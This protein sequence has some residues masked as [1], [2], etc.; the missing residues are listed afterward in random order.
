MTDRTRAHDP[1]ESARRIE[2][3]LARY[4]L[5]S[6]RISRSLLIALHTREICSI[7]EIHERARRDRAA[8][9][10]PPDEIEENVPTVRRWDELERQRV[11]ELTHECAAE[12]LTPEEIDDVVNLARKREEAKTLEEI[13]NL[14]TVSFRTLAERVRA[15]ARLPRG[16]TL[17][18]EAEAMAVRVALIRHFISDQLELIGIARQH[19]TIRDFDELVD[20][21][22]GEESGM[23]R[24]GGKAA[25]MILARA[26]VQRA[27]EEDPDAPSLPLATPESWYLRSD[28]IERFLEHEALY[29]LHSHKYK[30]IDEIRNEYPLIVKLFKNAEFP[31]EIAAQLRDLLEQIGEHPL[32]VRS[33]SLLEDR[34]GAAFAGKYRSVFIANQGPLDQRLA[35]LLGAIAEVYAS[36][37]HPDPISYRRRHNLLDYSENMAVLIQKVVGQRY[38]RWFLPPW[39]GVAVSNNEFRRNPR[40]RPEDGLARVVLGMGTRAVDR[41]DDFPR[42]IPLGMPTLRAEVKTRDIVRYSQHH[43]DAIDLEARRLETVPLGEVLGEER[44]PGLEHAVSVLDHGHLRRPVGIFITAEPQDLV[45]TFERFVG[46]SPYPGFLRWILQTLERAYGQPVEIEFAFDGERLHLLQCRPQVVRARQRPVPMPEGVPER[47]KVFSAHRD[48]PNGSV[49]GIDYVVLVDPRH[50]DPLPSNERRLGVARAIHRLN[51]RLANHRF[52]LMGP[53]RWGSKDPRMGIRAGYSDINN[54]K[55][56]IEVA[57][58]MGGFIP[59]ASFGSHFFHDLVESEIVYLPLYPDEPG[60]IFNESFLHDAPND[61]ARLVPE[62]ADYADV[63]RAIHVPEVSGGLCLRVDMDGESGEALAYLAP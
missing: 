26:I 45:V 20:R 14:S 56:L 5:L 62:M 51:A 2:E 23:G 52:I 33:S 25:G 59:E 37:L 16:Q 24:I 35:E 38:G 7:D 49:S 30:P 46:E 47:R 13:A 61:L 58:E 53:G 32:I 22:I 27:L 15:F 29:Q 9:A 4:P 8:E 28:V 12:A 1:A 21:I 18:P 54:T 17:L 42:M 55:M 36:T 39:A 10:S 40:V 6:E 60:V 3:A 63:V 50:Y 48:V 57:R 44:L 34:F 31:P 43:V 19:L 11:R 41:V